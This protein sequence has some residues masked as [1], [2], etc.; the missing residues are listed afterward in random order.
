MAAVALAAVPGEP[1]RAWRRGVAT[2]ELVIGV[3]V[4]EAFSVREEAGLRISNGLLH[5]KT[6]M[7]LDAHGADLVLLS[8]GRDRL[9][10]VRADAPGVT[11]E[12]LAT[13]DATRCT[14]EVVCDGA[15]PEQV[16]DDA[17]ATLARM[18]DAGRVA[19]AFDVVGAC[20]SMVGQA[21]AY[22]KERKQFG[23]VIGSFQ[24][25][26][27]MCAEM[28]AALEPTRSLAWYAG[29]AFDALPKEAPL[30][31]C[32]V[33]AHASEV[34]REI[35]SVA[36]QVHGGTGWTDEQNL[37]FWY[38]RV[39]VARHLLGGPQLLRERA[40]TLQELDADV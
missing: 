33:L 1:A 34:G 38:K 3:G 22:A 19:L 28:I 4:T 26:K 14:S 18:L 27:H 9:A 25:V 29:H 37:H 23:R 35:A 8:V 2:G 17:G 16:V 12:R 31:A 32:H 6:L 13:I 39:G 15:R 21:V 10:I 11:I 20:E 7:A 36:T 30:L 40:A 24:A 5:G